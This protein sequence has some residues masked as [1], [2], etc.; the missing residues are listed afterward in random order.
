MKQKNN[1]C[2]PNPRQGRKIGGKKETK[3]RWNK[4]ITDIKKIDFKPIT[5]IITLN[6][7]ILNTYTK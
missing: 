3:I 6:V 5:L 1:K 4:S 2:L 7:N